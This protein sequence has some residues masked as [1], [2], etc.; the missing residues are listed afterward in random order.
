MTTPHKRRKVEMKRIKWH[1]HKED[2][3]WWTSIPDVSA[4][5]IIF[6]D[7]SEWVLGY[8]RNIAKNPK[9]I[10]TN[11]PLFYNGFSLRK[12]KSLVREI[13]KVERQEAQ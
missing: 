6:K 3:S 11:N 4:I 12:A 7:K 5:Y 1:F 8:W 9:C 13:T 2:G 10:K